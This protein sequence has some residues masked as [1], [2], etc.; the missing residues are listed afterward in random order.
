MGGRARA[1]RQ[2][3]LGLRGLPLRT[4]SHPGPAGMAVP[5][6]T[7]AHSRR[8]GLRCWGPGDGSA[9]SD[10]GT[11][12]PAAR[13]HG[14]PAVPT[15]TLA[16]QLR[17]LLAHRL[18]PPGSVLATPA[19]PGGLAEDAVVGPFG[20]GDFADHGWEPT[21]RRGR[22]AFYRN[23]KIKILRNA[24]SGRDSAC[25]EA[26]FVVVLEHHRRDHQLCPGCERARHGT[27]RLSPRHQ[28]PRIAGRLGRRCHRVCVLSPGR[29]GSGQGE[30]SRED[31]G[32]RADR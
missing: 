21:G 27:E 1:P 4:R 24:P 28:R 30:G 2:G 8:A 16:S 12:G 10:C 14:T 23:P 25:P 18:G 17:R 20:E 32:L 6:R 11:T 5:G 19:A 26:A 29:A 3:R 7:V 31:R 22:C 13:W 15:A 9:C